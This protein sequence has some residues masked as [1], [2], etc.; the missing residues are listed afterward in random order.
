MKKIAILCVEDETEVREAILRDLKPFAD[1]FRIE[2]AEDVSDA[3]DV[4]QE[5]KDE[6]IELGLALCDHMMPGESGVEFLVSLENDD[7]YQNSRKVLITGQAGL[8]DTVRA[9]NEANLHHYISKPWNPEKLTE[10]VKKQLTDYVIENAEDLKPY[11][12]CLDGARLMTEIAK[13]G[14]DK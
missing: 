7:E 2:A 3:R 9:V 11:V 5:F 12:A 1:T 10:V 14:T 13:F 6:G 4:L 8:E